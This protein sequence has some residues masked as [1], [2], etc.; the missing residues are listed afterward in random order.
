MPLRV[1]IVV[2][3]PLTGLIFGKIQWI[4]IVVP[5]LVVSLYIFSYL[6]SRKSYLVKSTRTLDKVKW[7]ALEL[8]KIR[9]ISRDTS[10][11][12]FN[13]KNSHNSLKIPLGHHIQVRVMIGNEEF[14]RYYTPIYPKKK[15][16]G[17]LQIMVKSYPNGNVS[18]YF[19]TLNVGEFVD[20]RGTFGNPNPKSDLFP[21]QREIENYEN[22]NEDEILTQL[23][24]VAGGS[25]ITPVLQVLHEIVTNPYHLRKISLIYA[26]ETVDDILL[27]NELD[28]MAKKHSNFHI[29]Y[30]L[31]HPPKNWDGEKGYVTKDI[32]KKYLP[33]YDAHHKLLVCGPLEMNELVLK[34]GKEL[35]WNNGFQKSKSNDKVFVF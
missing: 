29:H 4:L 19:T 25:G 12:T 1:I 24:I 7:A 30:V 23:G 33:R 10:I 13:L 8:A 3:L 5:I 27:K 14:I 34:Y 35:G 9:Q 32:M 17:K 6:L 2:M 11:Y 18:K 16:S 22:G 21:L 20:F 31:H 26:N 28:N 15:L